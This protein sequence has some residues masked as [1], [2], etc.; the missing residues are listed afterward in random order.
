MKVQRR[1]EARHRRQQRRKERAID[2]TSVSA[3]LERIRKKN[4]LKE[5][6]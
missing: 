1:R 4:Q 6:E 5:R 3:V 2:T